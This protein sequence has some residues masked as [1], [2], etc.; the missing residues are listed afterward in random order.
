MT[1]E[2]HI[3][4]HKE[5]H[6]QLDLLVADFIATTRRMPSETSVMELIEWSHEQT[7]N[8]TPP[9]GQEDKE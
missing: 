5:L 2:E 9:T 1:R 8:P 6:L 3:Q 4:A 7:S